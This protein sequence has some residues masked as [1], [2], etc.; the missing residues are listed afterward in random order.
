MQYSW[1]SVCFASILSIL[2]IRST[3]AIGLRSQN[4]QTVLIVQLSVQTEPAY[5]INTLFK[6]S[7]GC[8]FAVLSNLKI[9]RRACPECVLSNKLIF[10]VYPGQYTQ[11]CSTKSKYLVV[12][13]IN[14]NNSVSSVFLVLK[15]KFT[16]VCVCCFLIQ[17]PDDLCMC[18]G[19]LLHCT[20]GLGGLKVP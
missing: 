9:I 19:L 14:S 13:K 10:S 1:K 3:R 5:Y 6:L 8:V 4:R 2:E 20:I 17:Q 18:N 11:L 15:S 12:G 7:K 16:R